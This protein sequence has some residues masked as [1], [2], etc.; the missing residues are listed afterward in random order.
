M[1]ALPWYVTMII[2][3]AIKYGSPYLIKF[4]ND[5]LLKHPDL[6]SIFDMLYSNLLD[7]TKSNSQS[8]KE[9]L[10]MVANGATTKGLE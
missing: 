6:K 1:P 4:V 8:R 2:N 7:P 10:S 3:L 9:A 5:W